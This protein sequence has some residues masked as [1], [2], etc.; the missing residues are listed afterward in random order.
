[1]LQCNN[2][3]NGPGGTGSLPTWRATVANNGR[4]SPPLS[5]DSSAHPVTSADIQV[6]YKDAVPIGRQT[7]ASWIN[8]RVE[9]L[10]GPTV[11]KWVEDQGLRYPPNCVLFRAFK[12]E[13]EF[14]I[15]AGMSDR[16]PLK[17]IKVVE[18]CAMDFYPGPRL[19]T[20]DM[21]TPEGFYTAN[22]LFGSAKWWMWMNLSSGHVDDQGITDVGSSFKLCTSYPNAADKQRTWIIRHHN[23]SYADICIHGNCVSAGCISFENR[24][25]L[26]VY[27][28]AMKHNTQRYGP[29]Q[30]HIFPFRFNK[31]NMNDWTGDFT[32]MDSA[33]LVSFWN[34]L[35]E[36]YDLFEKGQRPLK[37][38]FDKDK[39]VFEMN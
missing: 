6:N 23:R 3:N 1:M 26:A 10:V 7:S 24:V 5:E 12:N 8:S 31:T 25:F 13:H 29:L 34:N 17:R 36:G 33:G 18:I 28:F 11:R 38:H 27:S 15:W 21:K 39:Y 35:K 20:G 16:E 9:Q 22:I 14:E 32:K 19:E 37:Y 4:T 2:Q 30:V